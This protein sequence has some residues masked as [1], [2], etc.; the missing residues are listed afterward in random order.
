MTTSQ[1]RVKLRL[2]PH[3]IHCGRFSPF[4]LPDR[5]DVFNRVGH[6]TTDILTLSNDSLVE[7]VEDID[8]LCRVCPLCQGDRCQSPQG[9]EEEV[10]KWDTII[11]RGL[12]ISYGDSMTAERFRALIDEKAPLDF[13]RTRCKQREGC[14]AFRHDMK[15]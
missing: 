13:C 7:V 1:S 2:R 3:H 9:N 15:R 12:E 10:R 14:G 4:N 11:L 6:N 8:E 5:G